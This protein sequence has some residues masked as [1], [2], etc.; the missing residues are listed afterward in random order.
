M[1]QAGQTIDAQNGS[2]NL[3]SVVQQEVPVPDDYDGDG[4]TDAAIYRNGQWWL[5]QSTSGISSQQFGL[6][7]DK[8]I[9]AAYL[10]Q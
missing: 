8:P 10:Q 2:T 4:K 9:P 6:A 3:Y 5:L 1:R 7:G